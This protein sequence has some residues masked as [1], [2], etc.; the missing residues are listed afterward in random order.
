MEQQSLSQTPQQASPD[1]WRL[2]ADSSWLSGQSFEINEG[3]QVIGR[4]NDC[5]ITIAGTHLSRKHAEL[6]VMG[7]YLSIKDL[8]SANGTYVNDERVTEAHARAGDRLKFDV[9]SFRLVG[10]PVVSDR[11]QVRQAPSQ[12]LAQASMVKKAPVK[13]SVSVA[14][15]TWKTKPTSPGNREEP[16]PPA[17]SMVIPALSGLLLLGVVGA[18]I[19]GL[20]VGG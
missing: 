6:T 18:F 13:T 15:K 14:K 16:K 5:D 2:V 17:S 20:V 12:T 9:Y 7:E 8:G 11:T 1:G 4:S 19:Y 10:P 3:A